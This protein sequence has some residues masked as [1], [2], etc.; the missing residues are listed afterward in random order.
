MSGNDYIDRVFQVLYSTESIPYL[1]RVISE[2]ANGNYAA[3]DDLESGA[4]LETGRRQSPDA[5]DVSDSEGMNLSVECQEEVAFLNEDTAIANVPAEPAP[6]HDNS[7]SAI[8][9]TF[10]D[11][12]IWNVNRLT[13]W[14]IS[15]LSA[16]FQRWLSPENSTRLP[17]RNGRRMPPV[18]CRTVSISCSPAAVTA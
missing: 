5:E 6:L 10:S 14:K 7:V 13:R 11:C 18:I 17:R 16:I 3:L 8:E 15:R 12:Q 4:T 9:G 2:V 1:P